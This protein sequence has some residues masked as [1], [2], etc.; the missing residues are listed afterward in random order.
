MKS[1]KLE[2]IHKNIS[3]CKSINKE[4][5]NMIF[6]FSKQIKEDE[7]LI[8]INIKKGYFQ[9]E[10][11][12]DINLNTD[13]LFVLHIAHNFPTNPPILFCLT[14]L[15][16]LGLEIC[17]GKDILEDVIRKQWKNDMTLKEI[18]LKIP[19]FI[20]KNINNKRN[21]LF[22]GK[23]ILECEYDYNMLSKVPYYY[24][25]FVKEIINKRTRKVENRILM[26]TES[27]CLIFEYKA[28]YFN[29][30]EVKLIFWASIMSI[31]G[32][33]KNENSFEFEFSKSFNQRIF[34]P[35][36]TKDG[37]KIMNIILNILQNKG[38]NYL[39]NNKNQL[40]ESKKLPEFDIKEEKNNN[41]NEN[42]IDDI[43]DNKTNDNGID[44]NDRKDI[45]KNI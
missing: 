40:M 35:V 44:N 21:K 29:I 13:L 17:D 33:K 8:N 15:S 34:L 37:E 20:I 19:K 27:F 12:V 31:F 25:N 39:F 18:I 30:Y 3:A 9:P 28:G 32:M 4:T 43:D 1:L 26:I 11:D 41:N 7:Y 6:T 36:I 23:F 5:Q 2:N 10:K 16:H 45:D 24:F 38:I 42:K 14:S 22:F